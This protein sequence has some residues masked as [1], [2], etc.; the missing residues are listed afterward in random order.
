MLK[1]VKYFYGIRKV[2]IKKGIFMF[3]T[4]LIWYVWVAAILSFH[5]LFLRFDKKG[6]LQWIFIAKIL[7]KANPPNPS[8]YG[9]IIPITTWI[10]GTMRFPL[11]LLDIWRGAY[12]YPFKRDFVWE[13]FYR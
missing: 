3:W 7:F 11:L 9:F 10:I 4:I 13:S 6:E 8:W 1:F 5:E 2:E 12:P